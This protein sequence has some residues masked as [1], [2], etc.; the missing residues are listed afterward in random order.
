M[1]RVGPK[2]RFSLEGEI[3]RIAMDDGKVNAI[4]CA[5]LSELSTALDRA[6][7]ELTRAVL[8][9]GRSR[10]FS[11]GIDLKA[12]PGLDAIARRGFLRDFGRTLLRLFQ[13]PRPVIA[14]LEGPALAGGA[15]LALCADVRIASLGP[16]HIGLKGVSLG[17]PMPSFAIEIARALLVPSLHMRFIALGETLDA[18][19]AARAGLLD[20]LVA[21][22]EACRAALVEA[23]RLAALPEPAFVSTKRALRG[24]AV[25]A[26][27]VREDQDLDALL[28]DG[29]FSTG[30][31]LSGESL[32]GA[33]VG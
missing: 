5:F 10:S 6:E 16:F 21:P 20:K 13:F 32:P 31:G 22:G 29:P 15:V 17:V 8:I 3:A 19:A 12:V 4:D 25:A 23:H 1:S 28:R 33:E 14:A 18:E 7:R 30:S 2:V 26:A 9:E 27:M 24:P 11:A